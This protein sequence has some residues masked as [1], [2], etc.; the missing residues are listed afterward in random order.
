MFMDRKPF[1]QERR[2]IGGVSKAFARPL[3]V[4]W[5]P[6]PSQAHSPT[7]QV[8]RYRLY[9]TLSCRDKVPAVQAENVVHIV[10]D[11][12]RFRTW[13]QIPPGAQD[14]LPRNG[15]LVRMYDAQ[16]L[17]LFGVIAVG[18][19]REA[20]PSLARKSQV[21]PLETVRVV[22]RLNVIDVIFLCPVDLEVAVATEAFLISVKL[23]PNR[24]LRR[25]SQPFPDS[26]LGVVLKPVPQL[27]GRGARLRE[28][29][30]HQRG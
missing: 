2:E 3:V 11:V 10:P 18:W 6:R 13:L 19:S 9:R 25:G 12:V 26:R 16:S 15:I 30:S 1:S 28:T 23:R 4:A 17:V 27:L 20:V 7:A 8:P 29:I 22:P 24:S 21:L 5:S 14:D